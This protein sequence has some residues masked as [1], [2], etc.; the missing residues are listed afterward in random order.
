MHCLI[1]HASFPCL[2]SVLKCIPVQLLLSMPHGCSMQR[3]RSQFT[4]QHYGQVTTV[5]YAVADAWGTVG[6][7]HMHCLTMPVNFYSSMYLPTVPPRCTYS[8]AH[9]WLG[10]RTPSQTCSHAQANTFA[11]QDKGKHIR[12]RVY[13]YKSN[14]RN[15]FTP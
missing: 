4:Q 11:R 9:V 5:H 14:T 7:V 1:S 8:T 2:A 12:K 6:R 3:Q 10:V 15:T 13:M